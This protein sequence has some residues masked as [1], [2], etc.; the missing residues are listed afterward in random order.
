MSRVAAIYKNNQRKKLA[1]KY[2]DKREALREIV[3]DLKKSPADRIAAAQKLAELPRNSSKTRIRNRC[4][5][6]GRPRGTLRKF[7]LGRNKF[8]DLALEG[9]IPGVRKSSW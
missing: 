6:T 2:A 4:A 3:S 9:Q 7:G 8:R 1:A 5:V